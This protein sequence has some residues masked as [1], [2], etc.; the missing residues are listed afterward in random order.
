MSEQTEEEQLI[1][2]IKQLLEKL[3]VKYHIL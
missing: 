2:E 1:E 3:W